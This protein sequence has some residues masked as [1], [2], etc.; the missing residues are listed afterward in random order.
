MV[1]QPSLELYPLRFKEIFRKKIWGGDNLKKILRKNCTRKTGESWEISQIGNDVSIVANG[2]F[3]GWKFSKLLARFSKEILGNEISMRFKDRFP[4]IVKFLNPLEW[5]SLQV[6]P[7]DEY[8]QNFDPRCSGKTEAWYILYATKDSKVI[9]GTTPGTTLAEFKSRLGCDEKLKGCL[10]I[11]DVKEG[12]IIF[13]P[14]GTLHS[15]CGNSVILEVQQSSDSTYRITDWDRVDF[16]GRPRKLDIEHSLR[17]IDFYSVGISKYKSLKIG[18][19]RLKRLLI[20]C[21]KFTM[22][23]WTFAKKVR[24]K[25]NCDRFVVLTIVKG[26]GKFLYGNK[27]S[28]QFV[29]GQTFLLPAYLGDYAISPRGRCEIVCTYIE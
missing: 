1:V 25:T 16:N 6:H 28:M 29:K 13:L 24:E 12:D 27:S 20:K 15:A 5:I 17:N 7:S 8:V 18:G 11:V 14:P 10:N 4:I 9:R 2:R 19:S 22:E 23:L 26:K 21:E 3:K